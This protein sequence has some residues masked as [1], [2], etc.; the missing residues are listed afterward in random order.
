MINNYDYINNKYIVVKKI[1]FI[2]KKLK[3]II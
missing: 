2:N 3:Y 1:T